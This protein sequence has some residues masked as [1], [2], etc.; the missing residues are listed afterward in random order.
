MLC[1]KKVKIF[2]Q[3]F[4]PLANFI[5]YTAYTEAELCMS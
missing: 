5:H 4:A 2:A 3:K 1:D